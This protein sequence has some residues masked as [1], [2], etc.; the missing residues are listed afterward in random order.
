MRFKYQ[1]RTADM[2][3]QKLDNLL[4]SL[5]R[6]SRTAYTPGAVAD[7]DTAD[8]VRDDLKAGYSAG[9]AWQELGGAREQQTF[10]MH[11]LALVDPGAYATQRAAALAG[12]KAATEA[13][14]NTSYRQFHEAGYSREESKNMAL[15]AAGVTKQVQ[16]AA[17]SKKFGGTE[18]LFMGAAAREHAPSHIA[19]GAGRPHG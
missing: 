11:M 17:M 15:R 12:V 2:A 10:D 3:E 6:V 1:L 13:A 14:F 4:A 8:K 5:T 16:E 7:L 9:D 19:R 18:G